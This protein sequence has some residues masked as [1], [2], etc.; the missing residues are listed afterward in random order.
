[1]RICKYGISL[2]RLTHSRIE[3][4]REWRNAPRIRNFMEYRE[5]I[6]PEMQEEWFAR[7]NP[8]SDFYFII[9]YHQKPVGLIHT[10]GIDW[11]AQSGH[12]GLFIHRQ[13]LL[14]THVPVL[15]SL[16]MVDFFFHCCSLHTLHAKVMEENP[17]AIRYNAELG[18]KPSEPASGKRFRN[19]SLTKSDYIS[20]TARLHILTKALH[21]EAHY[22]EI[23]RDL[24]ER[25]HSKHTFQARCIENVL[26]IIE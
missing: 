18:F 2:V 7:L 4:V 17:V 1:M 13:E 24:Y 3:M 25:L 22:V 14:G 6:T 9:E 8:E 16:S 5:T 15:A 12:S 26:R 11:T 23:E 10:S 21:E 20:S 19:Y